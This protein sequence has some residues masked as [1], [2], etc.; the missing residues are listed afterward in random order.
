MRDE[1]VAHL[2]SQMGRAESERLARA[3]DLVRAVRF[4]SKE[5][6]RHREE[7][8]QLTRMVAEATARAT[9]LERDGTGLLGRLSTAVADIDRLTREVHYLKHD[10]LVKDAYLA[11][12]DGQRTELLGKLCAAD[13]DIERL[14]RDSHYLRRDAVIKDAYLVEVRRAVAQELSNVHDAVATTLAQPRYRF[15]DWVNLRIKRLSSLHHWVKAG[16]VALM[17]TPPPAVTKPADQ[18]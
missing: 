6:D 10:A 15:A 16:V 2:L 12:L 11:D 4:L 1:R 8:D 5:R 14:T 7:H 18:R 17:A 3:E 9:A 13:I